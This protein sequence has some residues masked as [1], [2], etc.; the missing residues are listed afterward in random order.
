LNEHLA[1]A[2][3]GH[4]QRVFFHQTADLFR[5]TKAGLQTISSTPGIPAGLDARERVFQSPWYAVT[6]GA[7]LTS[8]RRTPDK[9][10]SSQS[11]PSDFTDFYCHRPQHRL[12]ADIFLCHRRMEQLDCAPPGQANKYDQAPPP[13]ALG[14]F[15]GS[16]AH[17]IASVGKAAFVGKIDR[18]C[19]FT[20]N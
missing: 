17:I 7:I 15:P 18:R 2:D 19:D 11:L 13:G 4:F 3:H 5:S 12:T 10:A 20:L 6:L 9:K 8:G 1:C 14:L 16:P